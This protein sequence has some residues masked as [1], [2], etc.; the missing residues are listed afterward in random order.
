MEA[1][2]RRTDQP[3][4]SL[5]A[6][7]YIGNLADNDWNSASSPSYGRQWL[8]QRM[9][10]TLRFA[11]SQAWA[12]TEALLMSEL[13]RHQIHI[14]L[15]DPWQIASDSRLLFEKAVESY[16]DQVLPERFSRVIA[17]DCGWIRQLY[18][19]QDP[20][21]LGFMSMQ[22]HY[23]GQLLL[24]Q[25][26]PAEQAWMGDYFK[27][28]DDHLYMPLHR[29]YEAA[30]RHL[31]YSPALFAVQQ[32]LPASTQIAEFVCAEVAERNPSYQSHSGSL[33]H[34]SVRVSSIR[35]VEMFQIYLCLCALE[36]NIAAV[37]QELF[38][39][40]VMLY[41]ALNVRWDLLRQM[42]R[43]LGQEIQ[44]RLGSDVYRSFAPYLETLREMFSLEVFPDY[45]TWSQASEPA[46]RVNPVRGL[47]PDTLHR[48][49]T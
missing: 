12:K 46:R 37:Q 10:S 4:A 38:P 19:A 2:P 16:A 47:H 28:M 30:A 22:F 40:C 9:L 33:N 34:L 6:K 25:L 1:E 41:P 21:I 24:E 35:D 32:L 45:P 48:P 7:K 14:D 49:S 13:Q 3:L 42:L 5:W 39:L 23:T 20:R 27:V 36:E 31:E 29:S 26:N 43:L 15:I 18:T 17:S 8:T 44:K 11:S